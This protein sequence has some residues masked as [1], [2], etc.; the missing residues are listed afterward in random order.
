MDDHMIVRMFLDRDENALTEAGDKY[1]TYL[2]YIANNILHDRQDSEECLNDALL[3]AWNSI[4]PHDPE[5]LRTYLGKLTRD[6]A[7][8]RLKT[9]TRKKRIRSDLVRSFD[10]IEEIFSGGD[11]SSEIEA[12]ELSRE[13]SRFLYSIDEVK[14]DVFVQ[15]YWYCDSIETICARYGFKK[16]RV[17]VM[18]K[19]TRDA[20]AEHLKKEGFIE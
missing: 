18:L 5:D 15:R 19:R 20:L 9:K 16:S 4:P 12:E 14:R 11:L 8:D 10:E 13:I 3:A 17:Y 1:K 2:S 6:T 7:I